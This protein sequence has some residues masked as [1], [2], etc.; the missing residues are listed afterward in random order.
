MSVEAVDFG[1]VALAAAI[2]D[3]T[4]P[5][6]LLRQLSFQLDGQLAG[7]ANSDV[8]ITLA[9]IR[10]AI[11]QTFTIT[12]ELRM[13]TSRMDKLS[14][15]P[16]QLKGLCYELER[17]LGQVAIESGCKLL[18]NLPQRRQVVAVGD[19]EV[20]RLIISG[21][22]ADAIKYAKPTDR[23]VR[24]RVGESDAGVAT[25]AIRD[26]GPRLNLARSLELAK[27]SDCINPTGS[28]PLASSLNLLLA[29]KLM[30]A[31]HGGLEIHNHRSGGVTVVANLPVSRQLSFLGGL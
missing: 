2:R 1:S 21:F 27:Q 18:F 11:G 3:L 9:N 13:A 5:L 19:Y 26:N 30:R 20:L 10:S 14:T 22:L 23:I 8:Q 12:D 25:I 28:R 7:Q 6:V 29:D 17:D 16:L 24:L 4:A 15:M 31:M